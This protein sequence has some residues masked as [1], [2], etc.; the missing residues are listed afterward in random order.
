MEVKP[1]KGFRLKTH[2]NK[3][4]SEKYSRFIVVNLFASAWP[5]KLQIFYFINGS[6]TPN[7][8]MPGISTIA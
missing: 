1:E 5:K 6:L 8:T 3:Y 2:R 4:E 7:D